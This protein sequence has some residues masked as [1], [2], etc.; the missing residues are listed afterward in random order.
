MLP[1][2]DCKDETWWEERTN[3]SGWFHWWYPLST[4]FAS[5]AQRVISAKAGSKWRPWLRAGNFLSLAKRRPNRQYLELSGVI[6]IVKLYFLNSK[7]SSSSSSFRS[8]NLNGAGCSLKTR[9]QFLFIYC[10]LKAVNPCWSDCNSLRW[11]GRN[12][13]R[14]PECKLSGSSLTQCGNL[15]LAASHVVVY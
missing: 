12:M 6:R 5:P 3:C 1:P 9:S 2:F 14:S 11:T 8:W 4:T 10:S 13:T 7:N 15:I